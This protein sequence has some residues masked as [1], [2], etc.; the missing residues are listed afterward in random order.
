MAEQIGA[1]RQ[2]AKGRA[3]L[4]TSSVVERGLRKMVV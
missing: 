2:W 4:A 3:R 1:L